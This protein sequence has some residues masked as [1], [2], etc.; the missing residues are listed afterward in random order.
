[1]QRGSMMSGA[2]RPQKLVTVPSPVVRETR[3][4]GL[5]RFLR[6]ADRSMFNIGRQ[7]DVTLISNEG[8]AGPCSSACRRR[9][10]SSRLCVAVPRGEPR[11]PVAISTNG[12]KVITPCPRCLV[13]STNGGS[14][15][16]REFSEALRTRA[17]GVRPSR[18]AKAP[19]VRAG[20][21]SIS[22]E[23]L[24]LFPPLGRH[25]PEK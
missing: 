19:P 4:D 23:V 6:V 21:V 14:W 1:M 18:T 25:P 24:G 5:T 8:S 12:G 15:I 3:K 11:A 17:G 10:V 13:T 9:V 20:L 2:K 7:G 22:V 16:G